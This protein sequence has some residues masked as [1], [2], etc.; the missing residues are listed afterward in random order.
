MS[1]TTPPHFDVSPADP[2]ARTWVIP[3]WV[4]EAANKPDFANR[5]SHCHDW[6]TH[7]TD[8]IEDFWPALDPMARYV[9]IIIAQH[10]ADQEEWE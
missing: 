7:I 2:S 3:E 9:A 8:E 10:H 5:G 1:E 6:R 4:V